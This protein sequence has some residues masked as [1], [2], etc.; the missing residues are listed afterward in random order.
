MG[1][2]HSTSYRHL[3]QDGS[4]HDPHQLTVLHRAPLTTFS[5]KNAF[6]CEHRLDTVITSLTRRRSGSPEE[7]LKR[8]SQGWY[9]PRSKNMASHLHLFT[10]QHRG[11]AYTPDTLLGVPCALATRTRG[12]C[13]TQGHA[14]WFLS[15]Q[16]EEHPGTRNVVACSYPIMQETAYGP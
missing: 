12:C 10:R 13:S 5:Q 2:I 15:G 16:Q 11:S 4:Y 14:A 7:Q 6:F 1:G 9:E 8:M 3:P